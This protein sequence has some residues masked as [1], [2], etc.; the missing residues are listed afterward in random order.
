M[1]LMNAVGDNL[2]D[3]SE[4]LQQSITY[5]LILVLEPQ[6]RSV[7]RT[8]FVI[9]LRIRKLNSLFSRSTKVGLNMQT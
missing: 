5:V 3:A 9:L 4:D 1:S 2:F 6:H 8:Y 7:S